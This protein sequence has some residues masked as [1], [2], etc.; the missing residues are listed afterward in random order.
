MENA[1]RWHVVLFAYAMAVFLYMV[2]NHYDFFPPQQLPFLPGEKAI[3]MIQWTSWIYG[4]LYFCLLVGIYL[5]PKP[6]IFRSM[7]MVAVMYCFHVAVFVFFPTTFPR[8]SWG[9]GGLALELIRLMDSP[10]NCFPSLHVSTCWFFSL[11]VYRARSRVAGGVLVIWS[12][13]IAVSTLTTK[14]HYLLDVMAAVP[15]SI[16][17][18]WKVVKK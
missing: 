3:P 4:S 12:F 8:D 15:I 17:F 9:S 10:R 1:P 13:L 18:A 11:V 7:M 16:F 6:V 14:Q 5:I 2:P